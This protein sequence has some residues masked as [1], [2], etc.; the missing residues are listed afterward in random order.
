MQ[1]PDRF[2]V[3][4]HA[5]L[6]QPVS[7]HQQ[8]PHTLPQQRVSVSTAADACATCQGLLVST[9]AR[10]VDLAAVSGLSEM[11]WVQIRPLP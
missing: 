5:V 9:A 8:L 10:V 7:S 1:F 11:P 2:M 3:L 6:Q 4:H